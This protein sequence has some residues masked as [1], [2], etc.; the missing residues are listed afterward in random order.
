MTTR[1]QARRSTARLRADRGRDAVVAEPAPSLHERLFAARERKGVDLYR[2]ERD[3]KIRARYLAALE[4]GDYKD[5]PGAVYTKGFLRNYALYLGLDPEDVLYQW[6]RERADVRETQQVLAVPRPLAA[7]RKGFSFSPGVVVAVLLTL[8]V[9]LFT[10]YV[11]VQLLRFTK[12]P[13]IAVTHPSVAVLEVDE[14][15][16]DYVLRGTSLAGASVLITTPGRERPYLVTA[17][18]DGTWSAQVDLRRGRNQFE[19]NATDPETGKQ[20]ETPVR[21][22]IMVPFLVIQAPTLSVDQPV[23]GATFENGAIPVEGTATNATGV[24]VSAS[25][26]GPAPIPGLPAEPSPPAPVPASPGASP[27][28]GTDEVP[29][30][31]EPVEIA[32]ADD[33]S[34]TTPFELTAG[35][36]A[37]TVTAIGEQGKT[38]SLTRRVTVAYQGVTLVV[39]VKGGAAWMKVW[40]DGT[41]DASI[42]Q[43]GTTVRDGRTLT[44]TGQQSLEVRTGSSGVTYF[45]LNGMPLGALGKAGVPETWLFAPPDPPM[46]TQRR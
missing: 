2:A 19:I 6:R 22:F 28:P 15:T 3:T 36:W 18:A 38:T 29:Q 44:F 9:V 1:D 41:L 37:L 24:T 5:L 40:V 8:G 17:S 7:P 35:Q 43:S 10:A 4:R 39:S 12:P 23:D 34:F 13:T 32:V 16:T 46:R 20:A 14:G 42:G 25:W 26:L 27:D 33:G 11:G 30:E 45:T 21:L 31:P